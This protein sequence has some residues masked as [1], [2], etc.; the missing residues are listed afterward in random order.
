MI[1]IEYNKPVEVTEKQYRVLLKQFSHIP[2]RTED[3][4]YYIK[5]WFMKYKPAIENFL[6]SSSL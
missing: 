1:V 2:H 3:G 5:L 6:N 4:K